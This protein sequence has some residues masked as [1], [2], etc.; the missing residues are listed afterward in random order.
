MTD[1]LRAGVAGAGVFGGYHANKYTESDRA[2]LT[3]F[4]DVDQARA[5]QGA[6]KHEALGTSDFDYFL[7]HIDVLTIATPAIT[8]GVLAERAL[9]AG[10]HVLV[11]K[12]IALDLSVADRLIS[13]SQA[14]KVVLQVGHQERYVADAFGFFDRGVPKSVRSRRLNKFSGRAMDVSVIFDLMIHDLDL[15]AMLSGTDEAEIIDLQVRAEHGLLADYVD[16][17]LRT[18][19]QIEARLIASRL[20]D[21]PSRDLSLTFDDG[22]VMLD[23]LNRET[24]NTT[25]KPLPIDFAST[26]KP[27][28]LADPLAHGTESFLEAVLTGAEPQVGGRAGRRALALALMIENAAVAALK[29]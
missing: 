24:T 17:S 1:K 11:E 14:N 4:Y 9:E 18:A 5:E 15:L 19:N 28:A 7:S 29:D 13:L 20:E 25:E 8:H 3:A 26:N 2:D 6:A 27:R 22:E 12:P 21:D 16:V 10:K 23:F